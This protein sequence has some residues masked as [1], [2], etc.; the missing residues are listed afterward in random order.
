MKTNLPLWRSCRSH[1]MIILILA[2]F[3]AN[4][5]TYTTIANGPWSSAST[6]QGGLIPNANNVTAAMV[7]NIKHVVTYSGADINNSGTIKIDNNGGLAPRLIVAGGINITNNLTGKFYVTDGEL[8]QYRFVG[9]GETGTS[10]SGAFKNSGGRVT[11]TNSFVEIARNWSN[12]VAGVVVF[13][14]S[15]LELGDGYDLKTSSIDTLEY[16]S[17]SVGM[18]GTGSY[19]SNGISAYFNY[20]RVEIASTGG[21][22]ELK[23][24]IQNGK[25][26]H[27]TLKNHVTGNYS[28]GQILIDPVITTGGLSL[29]SYCISNAANY[30]PNGKLTGF[31]TANCG[32]N[33]F[34]AGLLT[35]SQ[36]PI[37]FSLSPVLVSGTDLQAGALYKYEGVAPG[38]DIYVGL[39]SIVGGA[40]VMTLDDN[41]GNGYVEGF[42]PLIKPSS[43]NGTSYAVFKFT[44]KITGT[45]T[46]I[47]MN[48]VSV[49]A[50]DI[51]GTGSIKEFDQISMGAGATSAYMNNSPGMTTTQV[52]NGVF[53]GI[54]IDANSANGIDTTAKKYMFSVTNTNV[55]TF[56]VNFGMVKTNSSSNTR[57]F[58]LYMKSFTYPAIISL[59]VNLVSFTASLNTNQKVDLR[60]VTASEMNVSHFV[61]ER[62][63]DGVNFSQAATVFAY[64]NTSDTKTYTLPDDISGVQSKIIYYRLRSV[65]VDGQTQL[66]QVRV[67]RIGKSNELLTLIAYPNPASSQLNVTVPASWQNKAVVMEMFN[68][69][70]QILKTVRNSNSGQTETINVS[71]LPTGIYMIKATCGQDVAQQK[72]IKN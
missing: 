18:R 52:G 48:N 13:R 57:Q 31:P 6:W 63:F 51:D 37:N 46:P 39:D 70:G 72:F 61:V 35:P 59:P 32:L 49:T 25:I 19:T 58:G 3:A 15:S 20:L 60:W 8:R 44:Y 5:Q 47:V 27:V 28:S 17:V 12:E 10:Q 38:V 11:I 62:S 55:S 4:A 41:S 64:G 42:Q 30:Q 53:R 45:S 43:A 71:N 23:G 54:N 34:P 1:L 29:N 16:T 14:N 22:F 56:T 24:G 2:G 7:I 68:Q 67:V 26:E 50:I 21:T 33:Y 9:G 40:S 69:S 66:S 36:D 65:D